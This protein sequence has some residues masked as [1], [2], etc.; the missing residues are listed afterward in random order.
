MKQIAPKFYQNKLATLR[1]IL[2]R[3]VPGAGPFPLVA[4]ETGTLRGEFTVLLPSLFPTVHTIELSMALYAQLPIEDKRINWHLGDSRIV[5]RDLLPTIK[6]TCLFF[7]DAH[8][9]NSRIEGR[10]DGVVGHGDFPLWGELDLI[11]QRPFADLV[12]VDDF[13]AFGLDRGTDYA[14]WESVTP[15]SLSARLGR[16][17]KHE[18]IDDMCALWRA[19]CSM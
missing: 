10:S 7:L 3:V 9:F 12:V 13:H 8:W 2:G 4:I 18:V 11:A 19:P 16:V 14:G 5:M 1:A 6:E 15:E 17:V